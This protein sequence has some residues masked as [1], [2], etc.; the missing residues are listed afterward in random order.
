M[1]PTIAVGHRAGNAYIATP[2]TPAAAIKPKAI[3]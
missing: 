3:Q 2:V 1:A